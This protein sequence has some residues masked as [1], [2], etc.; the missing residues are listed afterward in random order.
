MQ[1]HVISVYLPTSTRVVMMTSKIQSAVHHLQILS[2][3][4]LARINYYVG[5]S[6][7]YLDKNMEHILRWFTADAM[8]QITNNNVSESLSLSCIENC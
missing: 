1:Q 2:K 5:E 7:N 6:Y 4:H 8:Q 3:T